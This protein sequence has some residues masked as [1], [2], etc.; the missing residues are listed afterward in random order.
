MVS[1]YVHRC[2]GC[3]ESGVTPLVGLLASHTAF[4]L[5]SCTCVSAL[6]VPSLAVACDAPTAPGN[7]TVACTS[8]A[9]YA[10]GAS[11][12]VACRTGYV[13]SAGSITCSAQGS[14]STASSSE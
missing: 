2:G 13:A 11:C 10:V 9:P 6:S 8:P 5:N 3:V 1:T 14:W 12:V 4:R 7:G